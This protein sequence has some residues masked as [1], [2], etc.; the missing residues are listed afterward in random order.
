MFSG[1]NKFIKYILPKRLFYRALIIV[2]A[3]TIIK[4]PGKPADE[5][6]VEGAEGEAAADGT[7]VS[8]KDAEAPKKDE[9]SK[10]TIIEITKYLYSLII[11]K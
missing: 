4:E 10:K 2:A 3:P 6:P 7:E 5:A 1:L 11:F 9:K 8:A